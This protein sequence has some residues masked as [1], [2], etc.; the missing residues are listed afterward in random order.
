MAKKFISLKDAEQYICEGKLYIDEKAIL[1][2][3]LQDYIR[4]N[5]IDIVY[6]E[7]DTKNSNESLQ[8]IKENKD[9]ISITIEKILRK[10]FNIQDKE[11]IKQVIKIVK[12][13]L[14]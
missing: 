14:K 11:K 13:V 7:F 6:G 12:E 9:E 3:S 10:D 2:S 5:S 8:D 1:A 4:E